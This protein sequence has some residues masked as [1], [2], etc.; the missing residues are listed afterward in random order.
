MES[1]EYEVVSGKTDLEFK[2]ALNKKA[3]EGYEVTHVASAPNTMFAV[4][5][6]PLGI[7]DQ[8]PFT[9]DARELAAIEKAVMEERKRIWEEKKSKAEER[10]AE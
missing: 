5:K 7:S 9:T 4:M 6:R 10:V 8:E 2:S 1:F 3:L